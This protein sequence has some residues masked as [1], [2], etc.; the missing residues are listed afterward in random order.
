MHVDGH[1]VERE[2]I[3]ELVGRAV[4]DGKSYATGRVEVVKQTALTGIDKGKMGVVLVVAGGFL[5]YAAIIVLLVGVL[6]WVTNM[7]GPLG[8]GLVVAGVTLA[9]AFIMLKVG[10]GKISGAVAAMNGKLK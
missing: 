7:I 2:T 6:L 9:I 4:A 5:A 8:A 10:A 3:G 1:R